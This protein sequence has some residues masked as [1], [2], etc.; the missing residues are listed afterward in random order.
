MAEDLRRH[1]GDAEQT[2]G[3]TGKKVMSLLILNV[4]ATDACNETNK[5]KIK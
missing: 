4:R 1:E 5:R 2:F 3:R